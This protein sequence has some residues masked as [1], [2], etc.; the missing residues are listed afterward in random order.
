MLMRFWECQFAIMGHIKAMFLQVKVWKKILALL[1]CTKPSL[2]I[3]KYIMKAHIV[4]QNWFTLLC[5]LGFKSTALDN[6]PDYSTRVIEA[7]FDQFYMD[8]YLDSFPSLEQ[9][10]SVTVDVIQL[11]KSSGFNLSLFQTTKKF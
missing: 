6:R 8:N 5:Q 9:A 4:W 10:I 3:N 11:L 1:W 2:P 7:I